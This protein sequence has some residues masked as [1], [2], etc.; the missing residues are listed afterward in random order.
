MSDKKLTIVKKLYAN[1]HHQ[2]YLR[3]NDTN[4]IELVNMYV[5]MQLN[6]EIIVRESQVEDI[7]DPEFL[8]VLQ[9]PALHII[10]KNSEKFK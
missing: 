4:V 3:Q 9:P 8:F 2:G 6:N 7:N 5:I 10:E 1:E